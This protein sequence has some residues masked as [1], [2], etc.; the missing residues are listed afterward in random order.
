MADATSSIFNKKATEKLRSPDDLDK[1][2]SVTNPSV[3]VVLAA[4][5]ALLAGLL[6]WGVFGAVSTSVATTSTYVDGK[7]MCFLTGEDVATVHVGD[8]AN[9][10]GTRM[11][12]DSVGAIPLSRAEALKVLGSD[13][14]V[15]VLMKEDWAYPVTFKGNED[16]SFATGVPLQTS[17]TVERVAPITLV[18]GG[19]G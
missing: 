6:A 1:F 3:W 19:K 16:Y 7:V 8:T 10:N 4:C 11:T 13:Y 15:S 9:V 5:V 14:L 17:V 2:V 12:V 18:L